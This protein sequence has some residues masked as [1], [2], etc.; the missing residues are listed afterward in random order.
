M[1]AFDNAAVCLENSLSEVLHKG[2]TY[3]RFVFLVLHLDRKES[4]LCSRPLGL[5][6]GLHLRIICPLSTSSPSSSD[7]GTA[8]LSYEH[9]RY[10][11]VVA[12]VSHLHVS[13]SLIGRNLRDGRIIAGCRI[14]K[15][16]V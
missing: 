6:K 2:E 7:L 16:S 15:L 9:T 10:E 12:D 4:S 8:L 3:L 13:Q 11:E 5:A 1:D 14:D